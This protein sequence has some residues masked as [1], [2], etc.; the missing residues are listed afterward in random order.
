MSLPPMT[1]LMTVGMI[2]FMVVFMILLMFAIH[3]MRTNHLRRHEKSSHRSSS[4]LSILNW[5]IKILLRSGIRITILGPMMLLT[6]RG[7]K[8]GEP[9]TIPVD[10]YERGGRHFLIATH[11]EGNWVYNLRLAQQ[12]ILSLGRHHQTFT[13]TQLTSQEAGFF[14]KEFLGPLLASQGIRG[15]MLRKHLGVGADSSLDEFITVAETHPVFEL[16]YS[17]GL[18]STRE[19]IPKSVPEKSGHF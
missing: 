8:T 14:I 4:I 9:R 7:R 15:N 12:G 17:M 10:L 13:A 6:V 11:G 3:V 16:D 2:L 18:S 1:P 19:D 5:V